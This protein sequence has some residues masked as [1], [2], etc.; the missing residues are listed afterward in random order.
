MLIREKK[1]KLLNRKLAMYVNKMS[2]SK[3]WDHARFKIGYDLQSSN[4]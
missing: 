2:E 1:E 3:H 4:C